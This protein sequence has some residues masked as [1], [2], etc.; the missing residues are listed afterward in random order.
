[1]ETINEKIK[2]LRK[3][4]GISQV[5]VARAAGITQS[6]FASI[7]KGETKSITIDVGKGISEML[8]IDFTELFEI[9]SGTNNSLLGEISELKERMAEKTLLIDTL[10]NERSHIR[11][12]LVMHMVSDYAYSIG[13]I[14]DQISK[15]SNEEKEK[16]IHKR[17]E[18]IKLYHT[19]KD[20]YINTGFLTQSEFESYYH[21]MKD[22][23]K[24]IPER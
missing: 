13:F 9:T 19:F 11:A 2:R 4:K 8:G 14:D 12:Y 17:A 1:M 22:A 15:V 16:L 18:V 24:Y 23:I 7:E 5:E 3:Q 6:S 21:E 10:I 20:Y